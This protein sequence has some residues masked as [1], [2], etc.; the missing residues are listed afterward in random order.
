MKLSVCIPMYNESRV[1]AKSAAA[2]SEYCQKNFEDYEILFINDGS[3]DNCADKVKEL[4]LPNCR[5]TGYEKNRGKGHAVRTGMLEACGDIR[6]FT[7]A[8]LA[9]GTDVIGAAIKVF[10]KTPDAMQNDPGIC[11]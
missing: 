4:A 7:D 1:I 6:I 8:D 9:Y 2:L 3:T 10:E 5:V 11:G